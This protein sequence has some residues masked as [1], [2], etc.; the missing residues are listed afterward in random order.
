[1]TVAA[2]ETYLTSV[3]KIVV[4]IGESA[5][6]GISKESIA[7]AANLCAG[8]ASSEVIVLADF[9]KWCRKPPDI[10]LWVKALARMRMAEKTQHDCR[11]YICKDYP[12]VGLRF[13]SL[14]NFKV[15]LCQK[16]YLEGNESKRHLATD[17]VKEH[18]LPMSLGS[19]MHSTF[20]RIHN[21][22]RG[23]RA[24]K[25]LSVCSMRARR[26]LGRG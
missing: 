15:D 21:S 9:L 5:N 19:Y 17:P 24:S 13:T 22:F 26:R 10:F 11:C 14:Q 7:A 18:V 16:C 6:L 1:M 4:S 3:S 2:L 8:S 25:K 23:R 20:R 12:I